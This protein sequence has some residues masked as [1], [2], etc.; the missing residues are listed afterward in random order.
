MQLYRDLVP[1]HVVTAEEF[2]N[3]HAPDYTQAK[4]K[5]RQEIGVNS[6]F[7]VSEKF[8]IPHFT[9]ISETIEFMRIHQES[10]FVAHRISNKQGLL[11]KVD[12]PIRFQDIHKTI[13]IKF[14]G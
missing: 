10:F 14:S 6:A 9:N 2:W 13:K 11:T 4:K 3:L 8:N 12:K 1:T 5:E 7:L